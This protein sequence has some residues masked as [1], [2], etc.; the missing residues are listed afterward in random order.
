MSPQVQLHLALI[1]FLP[2]FAILGGLFW[3]YPRAPRTPAR[4]AFDI[5]SLAV[6][7]IA[8]VVTIRW[9]H[10]IAEPTGSAGNIWR[11]VV[12]TATG[13]GVFLAVMTLAF[14]LR[15]GWLRRHG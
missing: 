1:L 6:A 12:A 5:A 4:R 2:W 10:A 11:Q 3:F 8:F 7:V 13:Y 9:G 14:F 15:R